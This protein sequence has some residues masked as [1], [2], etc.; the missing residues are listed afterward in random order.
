MLLGETIA[1]KDRPAFSGFEGDGGFFSAIGARGGG[2]DSNPA[3]TAR[4]ISLG[5]AIF[6]SLRLI[7]EI[8]AGKKLL[9]S[10]GKNKFCSTVNANERP[11]LVF[12]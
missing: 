7:L 12:H 3:G 9:L 8:L 11:I 5:L 1:A 6:A 2:F 4:L 10:R